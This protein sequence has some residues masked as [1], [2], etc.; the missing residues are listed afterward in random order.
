MYH[1]T[2]REAVF[3]G[4]MTAMVAVVVV[5]VRLLATAT[6][7]RQPTPIVVAGHR[8]RFVYGRHDIRMS[9]VGHRS[10]LPAW[11]SRLQDRPSAEHIRSVQIASQLLAASY[12]VVD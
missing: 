10:P 11:W 2:L 9:H 5:V 7:N 3:V 4:W 8:P 12:E 1:K 6:V